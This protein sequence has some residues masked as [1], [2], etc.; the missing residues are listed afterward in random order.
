MSGLSCP[1]SSESDRS[2]VGGQT[3]QF[4]LA[5]VTGAAHR[6]GRG[7]ALALAQRGYAIGLHY[8]QSEEAAR[9]TAA[10]I[11][12]LGVPVRLLPAD[13]RQEH[14]IV[15]LF[16]QVA[17]LALPLRVLV[18]SAGVMERGDLRTLTSEE[19]DATLQLNLRAPW[20]CAREAAQLMSAGGVIINITDSGALRA[21]SG[22]PAYTVSKAGLESLT[23][24]LARTLAPAIRVNAVAPGLL[25][26]SET[27][28][29]EEWQRLARRLP[30][31]Q[32]GNLESVA[33][34][35]L[36]LLENEYITGQTIVVDGGYQLV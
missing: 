27:V 2:R 16:E 32:P 35:V 4:P 34:A 21:W 5:V 17:G 31:Q 8:H 25:L 23:R 3:Q 18:N 29:E 6:V 26:R 10:E 11:E 24:L 33:Q 22:F 19:W 30:M 9:Q 13:L 20:L 1:I 12:A 36:F 7:I 14:A 15:A 28:S